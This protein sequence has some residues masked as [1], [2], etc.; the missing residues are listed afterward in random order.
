MPF[1][2]G[3]CVVLAFVA[4]YLAF[5]RRYRGRSSAQARPTGEVFRDPGTGEMMRV[6]EDPETGQREYRPEARP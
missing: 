2:I 1:L 3:L 4:L 5:D 6:Y